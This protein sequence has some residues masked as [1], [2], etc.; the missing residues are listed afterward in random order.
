MIVS[1]APDGGSDVIARLA[2]HIAKYLG[3]SASFV[4]V[5]RPGAGGGVGCSELARACADG[6][7]IGMINTP[8]LL[9]IPIERKS[10]FHWQD[11]ELLGTAVDDPDNFSVRTD[12]R[13]NTLEEL[14]ACAKAHPAK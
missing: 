11:Y 10:A 1:H 6:H 13:F 3:N 9:T 2:A 14:V 12:S 5:N 8:Y 7:T 4:V